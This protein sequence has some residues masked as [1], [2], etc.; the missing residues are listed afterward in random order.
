[1][2]EF[3]IKCHEEKGIFPEADFDPGKIGKALTPGYYQNFIC[4]GCGMRSVKKSLA[5]VI[6]VL[7]PLPEPDPDHPEETHYWIEW[8]KIYKP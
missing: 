7:L 2:A 1:M 8:D 5:G 3:C 4:E 6:S